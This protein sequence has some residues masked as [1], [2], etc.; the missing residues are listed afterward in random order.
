MKH[1]SLWFLDSELKDDSG[2]Y[3]NF[4][5]KIIEEARHQ[6]LETIVAGNRMVNDSIVERLGVRKAFHGMTH[7]FVPLGKAG[8]AINPLIGSRVHY[9]ELRRSLPE[10][11]RAAIAFAATANHRHF[12]A[13]AK[14]I[15]NFSDGTAPTLLVYLRFQFYDS[16]SNRPLPTAPLVRRG[17]KLLER[18]AQSR[19]IILISDS[20]Q[21]AEQY[22]QITSLRIETLPLPHMIPAQMLASQQDENGHSICFS[23]LGEA[24]V[25]KGYDLLVEAIHRLQRMQEWRDVRLKVHSYHHP[26]YRMENWKRQLIGVPGV[27][28]ISDHIDSHSYYKMVLESDVI[29]MPYR[30]STYFAR[31]SGIFVDALAAGKPVV[32]TQGTWMSEQ[33]KDFGAGTLCRDNDPADLAR[34]M[35]EAKESLPQLKRDAASGKQ[36]WVDA[37][38]T[39]LFF[40][41][42]LRI[43]E[44]S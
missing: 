17:L 3:A 36:P 20:E 5:G 4:A 33:L 8:A 27:E 2:H 14:W 31:S 23:Y 24:R 37:H 39:N 38:N 28:C 30:R 11:G 26:I 44:A 42:L 32:A 29:L 15:N 10:N 25:E 9:R 40:T 1:N 43:A 35:I 41:S 19:A 13:L 21:L 18:T 6:K 16:V 34:A 22:R 7:S 12:P